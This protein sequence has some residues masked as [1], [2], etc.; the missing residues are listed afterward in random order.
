MNKLTEGSNMRWESMR[1]MLPEHIERLKQAMID[2]QKVEHPLLSEDA[3]EEIERALL[4]AIETNTSVQ[5]DYFSD[6]FIKPLICYPK[7]L[8]A[9]NKVLIACDTHGL[10]GQYRF[11]DIIHVNSNY[12]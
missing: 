5:V 8:D 11:A 4:R 1:M 6:G 7:R 2:E 3:L 10:R 9:R 12:P